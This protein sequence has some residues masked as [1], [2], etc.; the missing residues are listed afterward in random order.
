M[1][2]LGLAQLSH[3]QG[4]PRGSRHS[5]FADR[6]PECHASGQGS[7]PASGCG[8]RQGTSHG[9]SSQHD[10]LQERPQGW[11]RLPAVGCEP[12]SH[13]KTGGTRNRPYG[14]TRYGGTMN[15]PYGGWTQPTKCQPMVSL[16][17]L[18]SL[19]ALPPPLLKP[20]NPLQGHVTCPP[21]QLTASSRPER[22]RYLQGSS[23][24]P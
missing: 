10:K 21:V 22:R 14:A 13:T 9:R 1:Q 24:P 23:T 15:R 17:P 3:T 8:R 6:G 16:P 18:V 20:P 11:A 4:V 19:R 7:S 5:A 2:L 12:S